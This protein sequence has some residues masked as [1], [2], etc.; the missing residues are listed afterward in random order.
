M[1]HHVLDGQNQI[2]EVDRLDAIK[3]R[4]PHV[5][6]EI[7]TNNLIQSFCHIT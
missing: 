4:L 5:Y 6:A 2:K 7:K 3:E 1:E